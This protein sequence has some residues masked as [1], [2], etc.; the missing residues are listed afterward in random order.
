MYFAIWWK[1]PSFSEKELSL[2]AENISIHWNTFF[3]DTNDFPQTQRL[4]W[5]T[6]IWHFVKTDELDLSDQKIVGTNIRLSKEQKQTFWIKRYKEL[7]L[8]KT[9]LEVKTKW[10]E[11]IFFPKYK[12][13][14]WIVDFYQNIDLYE[15]IDF[16]KPVRSMWI[17]MMPAKLTHLLLN[18]SVWN[19][20]WK[21]VYDPFVGL[22]TTAM[23]SNFFHENT[24]SSDI[25]ITPFKQN[26]KRFK[27]T[28]FYKQDTKSSF[29]KQDILN[30]EKNNILKIAT[31]VVSEWFLWPV[32][33]KF[34]NQKEAENMEKSFQNIYIN[35]IDNLFKLPNL[36]NITITFPSYKLFNWDFFVFENSYDKLQKLWFS[37]DILPEIYHR[38][39]QKVWRQIVIIKKP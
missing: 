18:L 23:I 11:I 8:I 28:K 26:R 12:D 3:F 27:E 33:W 17:W 29:F 6:K 19:Q 16:W 22:W 38:K 2:F 39:W 34:L 15:N 20:V 1:N 30:L 10:K 7:D 14:V 31:N 36:E 35:W 21:T 9:D 13:L 37:L 25:N 4:A 32:I 24:I 5:F